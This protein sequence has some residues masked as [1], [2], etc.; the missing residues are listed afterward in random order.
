ME[1]ILYKYVPKRLEDFYNDTHTLQ[2]IKTMIGINNLNILLLG[3]SGV[4][5]T[6]LLNTIVSEYYK[7][8]DLSI[9]KNNILYINNLNEQ[10]I[11]Y[12]RN[13]LKFFCKSSSL[14][15]NKK[16]IVLIDELDL[17][18]EQ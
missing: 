17:I 16:K 9:Y 5:K 13:E 11:S 3:S 10:G 1:P 4:G 14:I 15:K 8:I 18:N 7:D 12:Y 6:S 2:F